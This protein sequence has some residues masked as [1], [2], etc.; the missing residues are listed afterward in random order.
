MTDHLPVTGAIFFFS[1][2]K[3][4]NEY[5]KWLC[6]P[7]LLQDIFSGIEIRIVT[8]HA[9]KYVKRSRP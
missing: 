2:K 5:R 9:A 3:F 6:P 4:F 1:R 7:V 8:A